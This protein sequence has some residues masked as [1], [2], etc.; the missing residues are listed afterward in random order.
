MEEWE[1]AREWRRGILVGK[2]IVLHL[3]GKKIEIRYDN[4]RS[5]MNNTLPYLI[6]TNLKE[7]TKDGTRKK[8]KEILSMSKA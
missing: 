8:I 6:S 3:R 4:D 5:S 2:V 1:T 7:V